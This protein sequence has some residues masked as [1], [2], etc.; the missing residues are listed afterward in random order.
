MSWNF[1]QNTTISSSNNQH[2][3]NMKEIEI[4]SKKLKKSRYMHCINAQ[5]HL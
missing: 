4:N 2:L 5:V 1:T 3:Q